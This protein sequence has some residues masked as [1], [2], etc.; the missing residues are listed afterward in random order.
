MSPGARGV[1]VFDMD[2]TL[3]D[4]MLGIG[5]AA[6][7]VIHDEFGTSMDKALVEYYSTTGMPFE[8]QLR[9]LYPD[10]DP[11]EVHR[12]ARLFHD[13][14][15]KGIYSEAALFPD[16]PDVLK[17]L[18]E[19]GWIMAV[20]TGAEREMA[21]MIFQRD[22]VSHYFDDILG[23]RE[24]TKDLHLKQLLKKRPN[25]PHVMV[26]DAEFDMKSA[27]G[28]PGF[29]VAGRATDLPGWAVTP[30]QLKSWGADWADYTLTEL[31]AVLEK[32]VPRPRGNLGR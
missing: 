19:D 23:S 29:F 8:L 31:P 4:D 18:K 9:K 2:G 5:T 6:A 32:M 25:L 15:A 10:E 22:G 11:Q 12:I 13:L 17:T 1:V 3:V 7:K 30:A 14:K 27:K 26:G 20:A 16:I 24:G 28:L 21:D